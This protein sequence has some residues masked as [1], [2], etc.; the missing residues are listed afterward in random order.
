[1]KKKQTKTAFAAGI[2]YTLG[3][4]L[5]KGINILAL[6]IFSRILSTEEFGVFNVFMS[7]DAILSVIIGFALHS[8]IRSAKMQFKERIHEYT[9]SVTILY[10]L[11]T[12]LL[13]V[14]VILF[15]RPISG[16]LGFKSG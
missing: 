4:I 16:L 1:M 3:N 15:G 11:N 6:P 5:I 2:G 8:S 10:F 14:L 12:L 9:A 13:T 7:Y